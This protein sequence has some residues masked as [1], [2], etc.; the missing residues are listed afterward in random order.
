MNL[1][2]DV[3][4][5]SVAASRR[6]GSVEY[7]QRSDLVD[8]LLGNGRFEPTTTAAA[9]RTSKAPT[10]AVRSHCV[11]VGFCP[12]QPRFRRCIRPPPFSLCDSLEDKEFL[13]LKFYFVGSFHH[14]TNKCWVGISLLGVTCQLCSPV[15]FLESF[16]PWFQ[17]LLPSLRVTHIFILPGDCCLATLF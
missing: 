17:K 13:I 5:F 3:V 7:P 16:V 10:T 15:R 8:L 6:Q 1:P 11:V 14:S 4:L 2:N 9:S 12:M